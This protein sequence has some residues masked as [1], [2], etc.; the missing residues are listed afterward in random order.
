VGTTLDE[1]LYRNVIRVV[2]FDEKH[3]TDTMYVIIPGWNPDVPVLLSISRVREWL[4]N[5]Q[6]KIGT[7]L[8]AKVNTDAD[9]ANR[10]FFT[11]F[12]AAFEPDEI[13]DFS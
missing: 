6:P 7:R 13:N 9:T 3:R 8:I 2:G 1:K 4:T 5:F 12:E 10:L 11:A